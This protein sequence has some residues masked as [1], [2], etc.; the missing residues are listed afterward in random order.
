MVTNGY[1]TNSYKFEAIFIG[2]SFSLWTAYRF[3]QI[4]VRHAI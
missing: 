2:I 3:V 1:K 4:S